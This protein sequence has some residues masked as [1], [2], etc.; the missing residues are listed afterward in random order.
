ME[1]IDT[2]LAHVVGGI[3]VKQQAVLTVDVGLSPGTATTASA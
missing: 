2:H 3:I 1:G